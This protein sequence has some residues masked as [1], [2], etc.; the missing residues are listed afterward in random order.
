MRYMLFISLFIILAHN[1]TSHHNEFYFNEYIRYLSNANLFE[2]Y[3][4]DIEII[5]CRDPI[6]INVIIMIH[7]YHIKIYSNK[8]RKNGLSSPTQCIKLVIKF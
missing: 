7:V 6:F 2:F 4:K 5:V 3:L 8:S 1:F